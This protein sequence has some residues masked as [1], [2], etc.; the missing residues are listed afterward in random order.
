M[1]ASKLPNRRPQRV[2]GGWGT[3]ADCSL[4]GKPV[5]AQ[6]AELEL[7]FFEG[8]GCTHPATY[9]VHSE[10]FAAWDSENRRGDETPLPRGSPAA[11]FGTA[12]DGPETV[13]RPGVACPE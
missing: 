2:W 13:I 9:I 10:C 11:R 12:G 1:T 8:D 6:Q 5:T 4:C 3:G 7:E